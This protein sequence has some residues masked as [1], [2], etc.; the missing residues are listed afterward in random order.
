VFGTDYPTPDGT[1][2]RDYVHVSDLAAAHVRALGRLDAG[3]PSA[4]Y[5]LGSGHG[6]SVRQVIDVVGRVTGRDVPFTVEPRRPG[7]PAAL[8]AGNG[9]ARHD[10]GWTPKFDSLERIVETAWLWHQRHPRGYRSTRSA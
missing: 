3:S 4:A 2:V 1:C 5:N 6:A 8:V 7:D 9:L 10:L